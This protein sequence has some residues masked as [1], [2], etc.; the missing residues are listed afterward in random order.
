MEIK[1]IS[2]INIVLQIV[3]FLISLKLFWNI[4]VFVDEY[5]LS[6]DIVFGGMGWLIMSWTVL[7]LLGVI[8][9]LTGITVIINKKD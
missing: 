4:A 1:V 6:P 7:G 8:I 9:I 3:C 5:N 2:G